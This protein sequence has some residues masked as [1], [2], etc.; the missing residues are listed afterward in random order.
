[1]VSITKR[2]CQQK[3]PLFSRRAF[4]GWNRVDRTALSFDVE[5]RHAGLEVVESTPFEES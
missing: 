4:D 1:M 3:K 2:G 5:R